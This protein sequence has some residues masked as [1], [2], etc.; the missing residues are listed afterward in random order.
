MGTLRWFRKRFPVGSDATPTISS[1]STLASGQPFTITGSGFGTHANYNTG[2]SGGPYICTGYHDFED[3]LTNGGGLV[4]VGAT[5]ADRDQLTVSTG[6]TVPARV[7]GERFLLKQATVSDYGTFGINSQ[8]GTTGFWHVRWN[9]YLPTDHA[10]GKQYRHYFGAM[11]IVVAASPSTPQITFGTGGTP[12]LSHYT[13]GRYLLGGWSPMEVFIRDDAVYDEFSMLGRTLAAW[14]KQAV[15]F[16][17][18][19]TGLA[20]GDS[21]N[22]RCI[23][24]PANANGHTLVVLTDIDH[25]VSGSY[26]AVDDVYINYSWSHVKLANSPIYADATVIEV[27]PQRYWDAGAIVCTYKRGALTPGTT[28]Y[29]FVFVQGLTPTYSHG[30][31]MTTGHPVTVV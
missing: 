18:H 13:T 31:L 9:H 24:H 12:V 21:D 5:Q 25:G 20:D 15:Y 2:L 7:P 23:P 11:N 22:T 26:N 6:G 30:L 29:V 16:C 1:V 4:V 17:R 8:Q 28:A 19:G 3:G 27:Q 10:G 14:P